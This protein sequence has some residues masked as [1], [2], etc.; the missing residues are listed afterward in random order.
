MVIYYGNIALSVTIIDSVEFWKCDRLKTMNIE[1]LLSQDH[2][3]D[4]ILDQRQLQS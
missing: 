4:V 3:K 2:I 1:I